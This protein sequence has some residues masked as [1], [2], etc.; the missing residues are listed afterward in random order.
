[1]TNRLEVKRGQVYTADLSP[2]KGSDQGGIR[3]VV[4]I[5]NE[6]GNKHSPTTII[7]PITTAPHKGG[8]PTHV[9]LHSYF[10]KHGSKALLEQIRVIDKSRLMRYQ[11][12]LYLHEMDKIDKALIVSVGLEGYYGE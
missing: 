10:L 4:V 9:E 1:M 6:R 3:P 2:V 7:A 5:Q 8:L 11:G 12:M